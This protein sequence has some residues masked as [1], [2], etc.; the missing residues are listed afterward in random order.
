MKG[1]RE[2]AKDRAVIRMPR[3]GAVTQRSRRKKKQELAGEAEAM[4][5]LISDMDA[6]RASPAADMQ[7]DSMIRRRIEMYREAQLLRQQ[8]HDSFDP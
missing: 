3:N 7:P 5:H 4:A 1:H 6:G 2:P 8:L